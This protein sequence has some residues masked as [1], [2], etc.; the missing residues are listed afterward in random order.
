VGAGWGAVLSTFIPIIWGIDAFI[1]VS[2]AVFVVTIAADA[3]F[4][5]HLSGTRFERLLGTSS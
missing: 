4:H 3:W 2:G 1:Y 5:G